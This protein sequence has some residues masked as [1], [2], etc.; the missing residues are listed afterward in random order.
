MMKIKR[1]SVYQK[2]LNTSGRVTGFNSKR[3]YDEDFD[4]LSRGS[5]KRELSGNQLNEELRKLNTELN[6]GRR[7][8]WQKDT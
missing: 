2:T 3:K 5:T 6:E 1:F 8:K 7:G 4:R